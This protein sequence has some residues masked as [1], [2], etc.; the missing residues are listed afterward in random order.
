MSY[1][2]SGTA[3]SGTDYTPPSGSVTFAPGDLTQTVTVQT[4]DDNTYESNESLVVT[5]TSHNGAAGTIDGN[6][7]VATGSIDNTTPAP[8]YAISGAPSVD[9][10]GTLSFTVTRN[11]DDETESA[12]VSYSL[13]GTAK[14]GQ[15]YVSPTG[16]VT[17]A[18]GSLTQTVTVQTLERQSL[19]EHERGRGL[20]VAQRR[21]GQHRRQP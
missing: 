8:T 4:I 2:L 10:G 21:G 19:R 6:N 7:D 1:S 9:A 5:L 20:D 12:T 16:S 17:F 15:D 13:S 18:P 3:I 11:T 14:S